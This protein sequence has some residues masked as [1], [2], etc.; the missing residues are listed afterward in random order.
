M[1]PA[2]NKASAQEQWKIWVTCEL[3]LEWSEFMKPRIPVNAAGKLFISVYY[4]EI[5]LM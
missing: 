3:D 5:V 4:T 1:S 2:G